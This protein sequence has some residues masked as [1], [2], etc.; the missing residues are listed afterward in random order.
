MDVFGGS[1]SVLLGKPTQDS[2]EVYN[3]FDHNLVNLFH[4]MKERT[5]ATI[6]ELGFCNLNSRDDFNA[7]KRFFE[8][9][10]FDDKYFKEEQD[11]TRIILPMPE[12]DE[13][14]ELRTRLKDDYSVRRAAMFLKLLRYSYSSSCKSF[15]AQPFD[16]SKLFQLIQQL[17][18]RMANVVVENQDFE[19]L[20][21][22]YDRPDTFFYLDPPYLN[23]EDMYDVNFEWKDHVRLRD[24]LATIQGKFL[25]SYNDCAEI[26]DLYK[27]FHF[28]D[29]KRSHSMAQRYDAGKE[30][31]EL[32]V[33]NYDMYERQHAKPS[34]LML[35]YKAKSEK[36]AK[37]IA[38]TIILSGME[39]V[40]F[41]QNAYFY[42]AAE[43]LL[44]ATIL[45]VAEF[46]APK[47]RHIVSVF[48]IIQELLA[49]AQVKGKNQFQMLMEKLPDDH[50]A[51]W[52]AGAA[53]NTAEQS[54][55]SVM[56]TALSRLN[57]FLDSELEQI[58]CFDTEIDA[59]KFC[60]TKSAVFIVMPEEDN[61]KYFMVSLIIQQ[62]YREILSV[63]DE[64]GG[65]LKNRVIFY[66]DEF[67]TLPKIESAEM[68]FSA[69]RSR[70]ISMVPIIQS[71]AQLE[72]NYGKEGAEIIIDNTQLTIF[73]GFAPNSESAQI[74]SKAMGSRTVLSGSVSRG[75]NDPAQS[76]QMM[77]RALMTPDE[78]KSM[79]KGQFIVM[80]TGFYPMKVKLKL[81]FEWGITFGEQ[82]IV[83]E[84]G[85]RM[86]KYANRLELLDKI[87]NRY[88]AQEDIECNESEDAH[89]LLT[90]D[91][92]YQYESHHASSKN[93]V[94]TQK[95]G[96][97]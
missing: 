56:S 77:E 30:F 79:T 8:L 2:F 49:P 24:T 32:L 51:K 11:L 93:P 91:V 74:L 57:A 65:K 64:M 76:L 58:L 27:G 25:L 42:D 85:N 39:A 87:L 9:E 63:A 84:Q 21:R 22:H 41:G 86:V 35:V 55:N 62:L 40:S 60:N 43:G 47:E 10:E 1:G 31:P 52:F 88:H 14:I 38:K 61:S 13:L 80:K 36:Y 34:Q 18:T 50:K 66:C 28:F 53:L 19:T 44:T 16:I 92:E 59:E 96:G 29:Y 78:L 90:E 33:A 37:I 70:R 82:Y 71:F 75:K 4:C 81:F 94:K 83:P 7:L 97:L 48:K 67:G 72:R 17:E 15:A 23:T 95:D 45:L 46:C 6:R 12:A 20:I 5:M 54:M 89:H 69:S 26:R 3:D 73:G 68:M